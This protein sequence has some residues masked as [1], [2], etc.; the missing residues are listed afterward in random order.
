MTRKRT[1][2]LI[3][4]IAVFVAAGFFIPKALQSFRTEVKKR[5]EALYEEWEQYEVASKEALRAR[6]FAGAEK[7]ARDAL[8]YAERIYGPNRR[9]TANSQFLLGATFFVQDRYAEAKP[10]FERDISI[11]ESLEGAESPDL[12]LALNRLAQCC[13]RMDLYDEAIEHALRD[14]RI[15]EAQYGA[16]SSELLR[17]LETLSESYQKKN[18]LEE[19]LRFQ[20]HMTVILLENADSDAI[21]LATSLIHQARIEVQ[22]RQYDA[23]IDHF[24]RGLAILEK[25]LPK[26]D[27]RVD[28]VREELTNAV[29]AKAR[30]A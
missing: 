28:G 15:R 20:A 5:S 18:E 30:G 9:I 16:N 23:S 19:A 7:H 4:S 22:V 27:T 21:N 26:S 29:Q 25:E 13:L 8:Q 10:F 3:A 6:E 24:E 11:V 17:P 1:G 2:F 14:L 12:S